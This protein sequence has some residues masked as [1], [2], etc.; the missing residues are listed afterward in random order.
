MRN[1]L[2]LFSFL[3]VANSFA[4]DTKQLDAFFDAL[5][6]N[7][8]FMGSIQLTKEGDIL[9]ERHLGYSNIAKNI[10]NNAHSIHAI[11]SITKTYTAVLTLLAYEEGKFDMDTPLSHYFPEIYNAEKITIAHLLKHRSGLPN[12]TNQPDYLEWNTEFQS[13]EA[14]FKRFSYYTSLFEPGAIFNYSNTN[15]IL[16]TYILEDAYSMSFDELLKKKILNPLK[17]ENTYYL[18]SEKVAFSESY[19]FQNEWLVQERTDYSVPLGAGAI[20]STISDLNRFVEALFTTDL[21]STHSKELML[22]TQ[23]GFGM[24]IIEFPFHEMTGYGHSGGIDGYQS[25]FGYLPHEKIGFSIL[26]NGTRFLI[27]DINVALLQMAT[28]KGEITIPEFKD[29]N[30]SDEL[31][32]AYE[33]EYSSKQLPLKLSVKRSDGSISIQLTGQPSLELECTEEHTFTFDA[34]DATFIFSPDKNEVELQQM[35]AK[36]LFTKE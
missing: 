26:S 2:F 28:G 36:I 22:L 27:N 15:Y 29:C 35:G 11:G 3:F 30:I 9:Y 18:P 34:V 14:M 12:V 31:L 20:Y 4:Q 19:L 16:L 33:G 24:G 23:D 7:N 21:L 32:T 5:E 10:K 6:S 1:L 8:Q 13:R 25:F 17:L